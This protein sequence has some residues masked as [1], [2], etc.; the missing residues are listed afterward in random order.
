MGTHSHKQTIMSVHSVG[1]NVEV[2]PDEFIPIMKALKF[3]ICSPEF[4]S[5]VIQDQDKMDTLET[6]LNVFSDVALNN[7]R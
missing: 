1:V 4:A 2:F 3:A 7:A 5:E 6:F